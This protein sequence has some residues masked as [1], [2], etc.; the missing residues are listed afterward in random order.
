MI[1]AELNYPIHDK[2]M[3]A[4]ISSFLHWRVH[5]EG[6]LEKIQVMLDHKALEYFMFVTI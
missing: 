3:L 2:E 4:I 1:D 5:L 6:T